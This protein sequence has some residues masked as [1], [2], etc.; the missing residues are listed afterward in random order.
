MGKK[1]IPGRRKKYNLLFMTLPFMIIVLLFNYVPIFGWIY[2]VFDYIP[3][4]SVFD[5]DF[6][7]LD[8][9]R[10]IFK[11]ANVVRTLKNTFIFAVIGIVLTPLPM[12]FA[13]LLNEIKCGPVRRVVQT[14]TT[15]PNFISWVIIFSL[16]FSL[17]ATDGVVTTLIARITGSEVNSILSSGES[18]YW[19]Q[20]ALGIWKSLGWSS[21]IYLAAIAGI[22]QEQYE[23]ARVDGAGYV[24]CA[25]HVT[26]PALMET[27][28]VLFILQIGNFLNTG[29]EQYMLF[30]NALTAN[31]I[32]VLDLYT[33]RI[34]LENMDYSYGVAISILKSIVSITLV[35]LANMVAKKIRGNTVI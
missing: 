17:F 20:T 27:Y 4:V 31:N 3:G 23:A 2:S 21:I 35:V 25:L 29:Y 22:D 12:F 7:G 19:F 11:D 30:K 9:F 16:A 6:V 15:L 24:Q 32:E 10:L 18:V 13:I 8:F 34:G 26:L 28:V 14:F 1:V 33:Y 5:C